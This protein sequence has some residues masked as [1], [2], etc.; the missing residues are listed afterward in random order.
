MR[1]M[2][3]VRCTMHTIIMNDALIDCSVI[4]FSKRYYDVHVS[5]SSAP[6]ALNRK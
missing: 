1:S 5:V 3:A 6:H 2:D 4:I